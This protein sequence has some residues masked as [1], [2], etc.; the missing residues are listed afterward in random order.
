VVSTASV[1]TVPTLADVCTGGA[2]R[3][4]GDRRSYARTL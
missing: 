4:Q 3:S 2:V 1:V